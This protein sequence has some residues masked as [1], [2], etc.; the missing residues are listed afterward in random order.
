MPTSRLLHR[1][2]PRSTAATGGAAAAIDVASA[3]ARAI[4]TLILAALGLIDVID[5]LG[6]PW[7]ALITTLLQAL[8]TRAL[9]AAARHAHAKRVPWLLSASL[10]AGLAIAGLY[11]L[12]NR[13]PAAAAAAVAFV[14]T[15]L[16]MRGAARRRPRGRR[17]RSRAARSRV[18]RGRREQR[19]RHAPTA[20]PRHERGARASRE[21]S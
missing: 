21:R 3:N 5:K 11:N 17:R 15:M 4:L 6:A 18:S 19:F 1:S 20:A 10:S 9:F 13:A 16:L 2:H 12:V 14:A 8:L 7:S